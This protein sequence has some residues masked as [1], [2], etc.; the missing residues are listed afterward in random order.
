[1][2]FSCK[3]K[4]ISG[5]GS[6]Q[7]LKELGAKRLLAVTDPYFYENG[8]AQKIAGLSGAQVEY[9]H[10]VAPDP[11]VELAAEGAAAVRRFRPDTV[12]A[13]GG[14]SAMD[15]AKAMV[16]F[17]G[18]DAR[19][20]AMPTTSGSG[21]EVTSFAILTHGGTKHP[22]VDERLRPEIAI[23]DPELVAAL[24]KAL[25]ADGGFDVLTHAME[26]L[27][28]TGAGPITDALAADA[29]GATFQALPSSLDGCQSARARIHT[30]ATEAALAFDQAGLGVCHALSHSLGG[31]LHL[32][33]GRLNA[34]LLPA[35][36][37][38]NAQPKYARL[39][40]A[41]GL[42]GRGTA[43]AVRAL[44]S[45]LIRLRRE[46]GLPGTLAEAGVTSLDTE[47]IIQAALADPC[48]ATNPVPVTVGLLH[49]ILQEVRGG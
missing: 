14:G 17:S 12:L 10:R 8:T 5:P 47:A 21:S 19:L 37:G 28:A 3:T 24:P 20:I 6:A 49:R 22:L 1:M 25:I 7:R 39:A 16:Y 11:S 4:I 48:C 26:A 42:E 15:L 13:L 36:L 41:A 18:T 38:A 35:V 46:L 30:A 45:A 43:M 23:V 31:T 9:F 32:P 44:R 2:E 27:V 29:F 40:R 34:I 33:H